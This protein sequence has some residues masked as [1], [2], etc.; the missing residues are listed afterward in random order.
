MQ[1]DKEDVQLRPQKINIKLN[2]TGYILADGKESHS[3]IRTALLT[4]QPN[5][6]ANVQKHFRNLV[7][8][9]HAWRVTTQ[10]LNKLVSMFNDEK[11][12]TEKTDPNFR[13]TRTTK[14]H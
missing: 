7:I 6:N 10:D 9:K 12:N 5:E 8:V 14:K 13:C 2:D 4:I 1:P 3:D 11:V